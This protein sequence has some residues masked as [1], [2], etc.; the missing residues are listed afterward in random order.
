LTIQNTSF[1]TI[2]ILLKKDNHPHVED[3]IFE[4]EGNGEASV[5]SFI[6]KKK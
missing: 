1:G 4:K 2:E 3:I 5:V 6:A